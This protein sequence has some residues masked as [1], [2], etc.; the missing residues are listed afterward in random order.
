M[1]DGAGHGLP[2]CQELLTFQCDMALAGGISLT[3]PQKG[4]AHYNEGWGVLARRAIAGPSDAQAQGTVSSEG[5]GVVLLKRLAEAIEDGDEIHAVIKGFGRNNDGSAKV[6]FT[7]PSVDGQTEAIVT[8]QGQAGF[9]PETISY[10]EAH[11]TATPLGDPIEITAL[12]QAFRMG[13]EA[14]NFCASG[15]SRA[16]SATQTPRQARRG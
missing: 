9:E 1:L 6:G 5:L 13:T 7:A 3:F 16:T 10:I 15:R 2:A 11:G 4:G 8:A 14:R 12:T